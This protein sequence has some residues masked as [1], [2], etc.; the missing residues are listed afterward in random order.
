MRWHATTAVLATLV[1]VPAD[2]PKDDAGKKDL[3]RLQGTWKVLSIEAGANAVPAAALEG[4]QLTIKGDKYTY[5]QGGLTE[6]GTVKLNPSEKPSRIDLMIATGDDKDKTQ[7]G[8][9]KLD[10]DKLTLCLARP[11]DKKRPKEMVAKEGDE[12]VLLTLR[13][14]KADK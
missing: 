6:E 13:K 1:L 2:S 10:G 9:Y 5:Q 11:G 14:E 4:A 12:H 3:D 7:F 8:I